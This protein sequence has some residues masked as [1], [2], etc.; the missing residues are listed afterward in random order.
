MTVIDVVKYVVGA[1]ILFALYFIAVP[2]LISAKST[3]AVVAG[4]FLILAG[5]VFVV[6]FVIKSFSK[7]KS[8]AK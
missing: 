3:V 7:E 6:N 1:M 5:A 8:D 2:A 4:V